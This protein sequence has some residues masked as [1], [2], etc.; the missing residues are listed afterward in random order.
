MPSNFLSLLIKVRIKINN[1]W[2]PQMPYCSVIEYKPKDGC[3][4]ESLKQ[5][6]GLKN[7]IGED[8]RLSVWLDP[9]LR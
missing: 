2:E 9:I 8:A 6:E 4:D 5:A 7:Q 3:E 1:F